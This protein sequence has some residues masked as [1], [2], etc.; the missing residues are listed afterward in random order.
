MTDIPNSYFHH[1]AI[2]DPLYGFVDLTEC[3]TKII[4][5]AVFRRLH[6]IKQLSHAYL[7]YPSAI[8]T[9]FEHV[10]GVTH[11]ADRMSRQLEFNNNELEIIRLGG[12]LHDVG[13]G[14]FSHL[15]EKVIHELNDTADHKISHEKISEMII[16]ND[17]EISKIL[18][19]KSKQVVQLLNHESIDGWDESRSS[20]ASDIVSSALDADKFDYLKRDSYHIGVA[21]GQ[22]DLERIIH[23]LTSTPGSKNKQLCVQAKGRDAIENY[24][25]GRYLMHAQVYK[26]HTRLIADQMF[27]RAIKLALDE[28]ILDKTKL[29]VNIE[30]EY[31]ISQFLRFYTSLDDRS[32]YDMIVSTSPDST[33]AKILQNISER[34]LFKRACEFLPAKEISDALVRKEIMG[35]KSKDMLDLSNRIADKIGVPRHDVIA[36]RSDIPIGMFKGE[37]LLLWDD[38]PREL[39]D[40]S[41]IKADSQSIT[42][43]YIFCPNDPTIQKDIRDFVQSEYNYPS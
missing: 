2:R 41:P 21:Y 38:I 36:H 3:E 17:M 5:T 14:P 24:R 31:S 43:F 42:K 12:L 6:R 35:M 39:D 16:L 10:L 18:G 29:Q 32:I 19:N 11:I 26:H 33:S 28:N 13:H 34:K 7:V 4:D 22:F 15:F 27:L 1:N 30:S 20:L 37:I 25:L 9:R 23:T 40:F 8:H